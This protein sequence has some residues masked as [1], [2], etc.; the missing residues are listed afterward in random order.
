MHQ[1]MRSV[2]ALSA[3][4]AAIYAASTAP[5]RLVEV[6][7]TKPMWEG[8][9]DFWS[10]SALQVTFALDCPYLDI[11]AVGEGGLSHYT[12]TFNT[13][14]PKKPLANG[15]LNCT[16]EKENSGFDTNTPST[17][18]ADVTHVTPNAVTAK[19]NVA[20]IVHAAND[21]YPA[22]TKKCVAWWSGIATFTTRS[23]VW[24]WDR[25]GKKGQA[26]CWSADACPQILGHKETCTAH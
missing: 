6:P 14:I 9:T 17:S 11:V 4:V 12:A 2:L 10:N 16:I 23:G 13:L 18:W 20:A 5:A 22:C 19:F 7:K 8:P 24:Q 26:T 25:D 3:F 15:L 1:Q 21:K